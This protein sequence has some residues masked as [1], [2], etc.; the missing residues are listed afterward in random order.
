MKRNKK[1]RDYERLCYY[2]REAA[3]AKGTSRSESM[4]IANPDPADEARQIAGKVSCDPL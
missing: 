4:Q 3:K 1:R 2:L